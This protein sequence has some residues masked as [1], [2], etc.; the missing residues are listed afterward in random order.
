MKKVDL[1]ND[2]NRVLIIICYITLIFWL[3]TIPAYFNL[4]PLEFI[5]ISHIKLPT[6]QMWEFFIVF[7]FVL[8]V[9]Y[10]AFVR[11]SLLSWSEI[12]FN[13]GKKGI[14]NTISYGLMGGVIQGVFIHFTTD[15]SLLKGRIAINFF[16]KCISAPIWEEFLFRV[17]MF[18]MFEMFMM[19]FIKRSKMTPRSEMVTKIIWYFNIVMILSVIFALMHSGFSRWIFTFAIMAH[20]VYY[21]TRSI[22]APAITHF[23]SNFVSGG[24]LYLVLSFL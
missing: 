22:V 24:F 4:I 2:P 3:F 14:F 17:L 7:P 20:L 21:R 16:E 18:S 19:L 1:K 15:H 5:T 10:L 6:F 11:K 9:T 23:I 8:M 12:G 13:K